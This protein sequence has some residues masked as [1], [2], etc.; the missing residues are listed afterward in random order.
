LRAE[1][2]LAS[3][4][5]AMNAGL[6]IPCDGN[7]RFPLFA[8]FVK[9]HEIEMA[10]GDI[11]RQGKRSVKL[12]Q[13]DDVGRHHGRIENTRLYVYGADAMAASRLIDRT[14]GTTLRK[15]EKE[16]CRQSKK[17][18]DC[19]FIGFEARREHQSSISARDVDR[20][21]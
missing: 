12:T 9:L 6:A 19:C 5:Q 15:K 14:K 1:K 18:V 10:S 16:K 21:G 4:N 2:R 13:R 17:D 20:R 7:A 3:G 11:P 8:S